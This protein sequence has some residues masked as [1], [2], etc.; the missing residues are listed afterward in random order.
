[1]SHLDR[2]FADEPQVLD[3]SRAAELLG[4]K[5]STLYKWLGEGAIPGYRVA[6]RWIIY[7]DELKE[8]IARGR[9]LP[10]AD[11]DDENEEQSPP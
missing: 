4:C 2:M 7:R 10:D 5:R 9:N 6:G 3:P 8:T 11:D 1:M